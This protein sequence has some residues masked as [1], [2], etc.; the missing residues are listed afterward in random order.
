MNYEEFVRRIKSKTKFDKCLYYGLCIVV[1]FLSIFLFC[2]INVRPEKFEGNQIFHY[3]GFSFLLFL[4]IY[5]LYKLP[6]RYK[7]VTISS[8]QNLIKKKAAIDS[9]L[10]N[11]NLKIVSDSNYLSFNYSKSF[12]SP[13]YFIYLFYDED[14]ISFSIQGYD[15]SSGGFI[16]FGGTEKLRKKVENELIAMIA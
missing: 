5:G 11:L 1:I 2:F 14:K 4:G 10:S 3:L 9:L 16:D 7:I 6:N 15:S 12:W 8:T 13:S